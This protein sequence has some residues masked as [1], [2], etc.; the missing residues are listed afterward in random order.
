VLLKKAD[1]GGIIDLDATFGTSVGHPIDN[2]KANVATAHAASSERVTS[3]INKWQTLVTKRDVIRAANAD[4][5][6]VSVIEKTEK[7]IELDTTRVA[8]K[9]RKEDFIIMTPTHRT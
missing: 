3:I 5:R 9:K 6:W 7:K 1:E 2:K 4:E 8:G